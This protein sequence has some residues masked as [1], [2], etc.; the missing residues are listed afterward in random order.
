MDGRFVSYL[1]VST[2]RQG[3]SGL[4]LEA[5]RQAVS[6]YLN[7]GRWTLAR[8]YIEVETGK[9]DTRPQLA[10]ALSECR[11]TGATLIVAKV[12]LLARNVRF[13]MEV[14]DGS[15]A[16]GVVFA[17]LP[18]IPPGP[19]GRFLV[20]Q[21]AAVAELEAGLISQRTK[22]ALEAAK[23]RGSKLGGWRG[24][25]KVAPELGREVQRKEA[26]KFAE[27]VAPRVI[28]LRQRGLS[29]RQIAAEL[30]TMGVKTRR[31]G[32]W[33]CETVRDVLRRTVND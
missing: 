22:A 1:R 19:T 14:L 13:L 11:I 4:G 25:H 20:Q 24:G 23:A 3:Q 26:Q 33:S 8:E 18:S 7:G 29:L 2:T 10:A 21:M 9:S 15:G 12:D 16:G 30:S 31:G 5:Q 27:A 32:A 6:A 17:D 28:E